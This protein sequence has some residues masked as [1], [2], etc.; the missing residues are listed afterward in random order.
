MEIEKILISGFRNYLDA[1]INFNKSTLVIGA[2]DSGKTNLI[3]AI[4]LL[5]DK[6]LPESDLEPSEAD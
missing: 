2:N 5:L 6:S 1:N 4:R 3:Y